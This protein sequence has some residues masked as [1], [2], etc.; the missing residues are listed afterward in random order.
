MTT[1][2]ATKT[3]IRRAVIAT[4]ALGFVTLVALAARPRPLPVET[5]PARRGTLEVT[6]G[7]DGRT[8][9]KDRYIVSA[10]TTG[11]LMRIDHAVGDALE[12]DAP[13]AVM[14]PTRAELMDART[15]AVTEARVQAAEANVQLSRAAT[16]AA[17]T[18]VARAQ[19]ERDRLAPLAESGAVARSQSDDA[20]FALRSAREALSSARFG[21]RVASHELRMARAASAAGEPRGDETQ[22]VIPS[23]VAGRVLRVIR[24]SEGVTQAGA[25]LLEVGDPG[26][27]EV[28][29]DVLTTEAV[30]IEPGDL[31]RIV[32][33][34]GD[35]ELDA[36]VRLVEP[37]AFT[38]RSA[39]GVEEQRVNVVLELTSER[40]HWGR[41]GDGF[42]VEVE[43]IVEE[44]D[45]AL[46]VPASALFRDGEGFAIY[47]VQ[48]GIARL[49]P[50]EV[51]A[52][53]P[54]EVAI[55]AELPD[56]AR[57]IVHPPD[58][59]EDGSEVEVR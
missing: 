16:R 15:Q 25:P 56:D 52:R 21:A 7:E 33:W 11:T 1:Q 58:A 10:P 48:D 12:V 53:T 54:D 23:P 55:E 20:E 30:R 4:L 47:A 49:V 9:V 43:I 42:R 18:A 26:A 38:A 3:W 22:L 40:D 14:L 28:V 59:V 13:V 17:E 51:R 36:R 19:A 32:R 39:L 50:V 29:V 2:P 57:V 5:Q 45:N 8:R 37:S 31:A 34:G 41:L 27:L 46:L 35:A 44:V 24:E 6:I